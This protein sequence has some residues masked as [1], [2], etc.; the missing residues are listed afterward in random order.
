V[1]YAGAQ[2]TATAVA[3]NRLEGF[4]NEGTNIGETIVG[5]FGFV[6]TGGNPVN[7]AFD[8]LILVENEAGDTD[9]PAEFHEGQAVNNDSGSPLFSVE[10]GE[11]Q[12]EGVAYAV[13][14]L[15]GNFEGPNETRDASFYS[16]VGSYSDDINSLVSTFPAPVPEPSSLA[17]LSLGGLTL[18][19][20]KR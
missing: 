6:D 7:A 8:Q 13:G 18:L 11:L 2:L 12:L 17:L 10:N 20:R 4:Y 14:S 5:N 1:S 3:Q 19:R 16:Y 9:N 15:T